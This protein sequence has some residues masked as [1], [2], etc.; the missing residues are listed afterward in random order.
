MQTKGYE[1]EGKRQFT[2][3]E[4]YPKQR[5]RKIKKKIFSSS[6]TVS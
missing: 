4:E 6:K 2:V 1:E 5:K 3:I